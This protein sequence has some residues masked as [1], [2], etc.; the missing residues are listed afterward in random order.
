MFCKA[1]SDSVM[2]QPLAAVTRSREQIW[3]WTGRL[4]GELVQVR[5][6]CKCARHFFEKD[7]GITVTRIEHLITVIPTSYQRRVNNDE[8][9]A[10]CLAQEWWQRYCWELLRQAGVKMQ[11]LVQLVGGCPLVALVLSCSILP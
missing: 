4:V 5:G 8:R 10:T 11:C 7:K 2:R 3:A 1:V 6:L 9:R